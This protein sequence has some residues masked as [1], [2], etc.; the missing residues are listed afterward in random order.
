MKRVV[1]IA[2]GDILRTL[3]RDE[4]ERLTRTLNLCGFVENSTPYDVRIV[5]EGEEAAIDLFIEQVKMT[6][7]PFNVKELIVNDEPVQGDFE[8]F[9][10]RRGEW[11]EE[12][13][14]LYYAWAKILARSIEKDP[15]SVPPSERSVRLGERPGE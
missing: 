10:I 11:H 5:A 4:V 8:Y 6:Q 3:Y 2:K 1:L 12:L 14:E 13:G 15:T 9:E 7:F